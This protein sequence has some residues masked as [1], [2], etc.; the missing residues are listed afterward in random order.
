MNRANELMS[1]ISVLLLHENVKDF[2]LSTL[3]NILFVS[4]QLFT[5]TN[6]LAKLIAIFIPV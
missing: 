1:G 6:S 4:G 2:V 3:M 5:D